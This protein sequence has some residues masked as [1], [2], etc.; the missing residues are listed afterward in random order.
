MLLSTGHAPPLMRRR[1]LLL[2]LASALLFAAAVPFAKLPLLPL[3][4]FIP[5]YQSALIV[6]DLVTAMLLFGQHRVQ[7][8]ARLGLLAAGYLFTA[9]L[10][11]VHLLSFPGLFASGG[12]LGAGMQTTAWL[13]MAW[14]AG[15][16]LF[17]IAYVL[18]DDRT[19]GRHHDDE[20]SRHDISEQR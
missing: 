4:G 17:V 13:Y 9:L 8:E 2:V 6:G 19:P 18:T 20:Y 15:F 11:G 16:P 1:A 7:R 5:V 10:A 3:P 14:H 12:L